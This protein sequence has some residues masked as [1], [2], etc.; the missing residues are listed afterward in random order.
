MRHIIVTCNVFCL[1]CMYRLYKKCGI[2]HV[3]CFLASAWCMC[4][5]MYPIVSPP[6]WIL[7]SWLVV[8]VHV[9]CLCYKKH[10][11]HAILFF[12][13]EGVVHVFYY[14]SHCFFNAAH[15]MYYG[16]LGVVHVFYDV[17][18]CFFQC[19][20]CNVFCF[21]GS[22]TCFFL[23]VPLFFSMRPTSLKFVK[24]MVWTYFSSWPK[25]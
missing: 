14:V 20:T 15:V 1:P 8:G 2:C 12:S 4:F 16:F 23:Y 18:Q 6:P 5:I 9:V 10:A 19:G 17:Y 24:W 3:F 13:G 21:V 11:A 22:G 7:F 25:L